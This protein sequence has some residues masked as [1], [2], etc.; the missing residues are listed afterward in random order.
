MDGQDPKA[1]DITS[2]LTEILRRLRYYQ[3]TGNETSMNNNLSFYKYFNTKTVEV[4]G[5]KARLDEN[6]ELHFVMLSNIFPTL[7]MN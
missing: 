6:R 5:G 7:D 1:F 2:N 3:I 4:G